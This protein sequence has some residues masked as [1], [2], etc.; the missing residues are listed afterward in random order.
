[1][2]SYVVVVS[3]EVQKGEIFRA[4]IYACGMLQ[5]L[6]RETYLHSLSLSVRVLQ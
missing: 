4:G 1:M 3:G 6:T 5:R 2:L